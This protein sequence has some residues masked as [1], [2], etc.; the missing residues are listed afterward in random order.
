MVF[1]LSSLKK[2]LSL[3]SES[4]LNCLLWW[5]FP[6][7]A[8]DKFW[9]FLYT[10]RNPK[11]KNCWRLIFLTLFLSE[12]SLF[13]S[14]STE[15][16]MLVTSTG[17]TWSSMIC[18]KESRPTKSI[19]FQLHYLGHPVLCNWRICVL[20]ETSWPTIGPNCSQQAWEMSWN[21]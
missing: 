6:A 9:L 1:R 17:L 21:V 12:V 16:D 2:R 4:T 13:L 7:S 10:L 3:K 15:K 20:L 19:S 18:T 14:C 11:P 5:E 8:C